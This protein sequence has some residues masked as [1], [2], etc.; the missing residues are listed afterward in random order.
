MYEWSE[1]NRS[2][3]GFDGTVVNWTMPSLH[4]RSLS[5]WGIIKQFQFC[6][7]FKLSMKMFAD[8]LHFFK[9]FLSSFKHIFLIDDYHVKK[10]IKTKRK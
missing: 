2:V 1:L 4:G 7:Y 6:F 3:K 8:I 10:M 5:L 9:E